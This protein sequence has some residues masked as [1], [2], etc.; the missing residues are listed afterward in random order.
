VVHPVSPNTAMSAEQ[1]NALQA[2]E[3]NTAPSKLISVQAAL[4]TAFSTTDIPLVVPETPSTG[5]SPTESFATADESEQ[6][7]GGAVEATPHDAEE[8][9]KAEQER[10]LEKWQHENALQREKAERTRKEWEDRRAQGEAFPETDEF[11]GAHLAKV[12]NKA[13][14]GWEKVEDDN[15]VREI[16]ESPSPVDA[17]DIVTG[18]VQGKHDTQ[19]LQVGFS[20]TDN[21]LSLITCYR[22]C[23]LV[24][25]ALRP[26]HR[27]QRSSQ[28]RTMSQNA[29]TTVRQQG[30]RNGI[31]SQP[32]WLPHIPRY[33]SPTRRP[34]PR[35]NPR[36]SLTTA[37]N[38]IA[39]TTTTHTNGP[40]PPHRSP[41][42][43]R[44]CRPK[45]A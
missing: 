40:N 43:I 1:E 5:T 9:W 22:V 29:H 2:S 32:A 25:R 26:L 27:L 13:D 42:S 6:S 7:P 39:T 3:L 35:P 16:V 33:P 14:G 15:I 41:S 8:E 24:R 23:Y 45:R 12:Q 20:A 30:P 44:A 18:Q 28:T 34:R 10:N 36:A 38:I 19:H 37:T 31:R 21:F 4:S 17:R 11:L